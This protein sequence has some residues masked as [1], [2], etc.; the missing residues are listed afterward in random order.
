MLGRGSPQARILMAKFAVIEGR[1]PAKF[2]DALARQALRRFIVEISRA[3][4]RGHGVGGRSTHEL[5]KLFQHLSAT[6]TSLSSIMDDV[7][8][9]LHAAECEDLARKWQELAVKVE[10]L[11]GNATL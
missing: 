8:A 4:A 10:R 9:E 2:Q 11:D 7:I 6:D 1:D 3:L 5:G